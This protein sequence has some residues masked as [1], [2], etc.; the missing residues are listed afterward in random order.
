MCVCVYQKKSQ[1]MNRQEKQHLTIA[2]KQKGRIK[3]YTHNHKAQGTRHKA[4]GT[5]HTA[6]GTRH[7]PQRKPQTT[8]THRARSLSKT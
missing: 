3:K 6:H 5:R 2:N 4:Q 7:K 1:G 8:T